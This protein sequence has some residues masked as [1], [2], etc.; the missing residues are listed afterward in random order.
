MQPQIARSTMKIRH[1]IKGKNR[2]R[3]RID[4]LEI[5]AQWAGRVNIQ[6]MTKT[7]ALVEK[8]IFPMMEKIT[9]P[10]ERMINAILYS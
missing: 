8:T 2:K 3:K 4:V 1:P 6:I 10:V 7:S 9:A 5:L